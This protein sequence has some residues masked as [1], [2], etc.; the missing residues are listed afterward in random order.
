L[1]RRPAQLGLLTELT[2]KASI[3]TI[4]PTKPGQT[5]EFN[6]KKIIQTEIEDDENFGNFPKNTNARI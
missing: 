6:A 4:V 1:G 3:G 5:R 2:S